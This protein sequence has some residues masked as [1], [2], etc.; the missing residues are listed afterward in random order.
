M[1]KLR[2]ALITTAFLFSAIGTASAGEMG[3]P[4]PVSTITTASASAE[5]SEISNT[6]ESEMQCVKSES[7]MTSSIIDAILDLLKF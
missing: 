7:T 2:F 5:E 4:K 6:T 3:F 1:K